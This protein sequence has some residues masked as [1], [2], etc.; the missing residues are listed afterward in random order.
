MHPRTRIASRK[1]CRFALPSLLAGCLWFALP[2]RGQDLEPRADVNLPT[3]LN[4]LVA[5]YSYS[6]GGLSTDPALPVDDAHL[7]LNAGIFA[8]ARS[9]N[10]WGCSGKVD[11]VVP[12]ASLSGD[13]IVA[14]QFRE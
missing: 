11:M 4:F 6:D 7:T 5:I 13:A 8:Y 1:I 14:G 12:Y 10:F 9:M 2:T 3:G